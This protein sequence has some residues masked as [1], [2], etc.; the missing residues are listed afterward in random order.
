[1][2]R[3]T[4]PNR[5]ATWFPRSLSRGKRSLYWSAMKN[6]CCTVCGEIAI[7]V[8]AAYLISGTIRFIA[9]NCATQNGHQ[10]PRKQ[11]IIRSPR[12]SSSFDETAF[13]LSPVNSDG[14]YF[15]PSG[16]T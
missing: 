16:R 13:L 10:R 14:G 11:Q 1:G 3:Q 12:P 8:A 2:T 4:R 15:S 9:S 7:S 5:R 6:D